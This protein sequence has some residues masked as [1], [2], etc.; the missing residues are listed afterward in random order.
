MEVRT[1]LIPYLYLTQAVR[2]GNIQQFQHIAN[3]TI[4]KLVFKTD[5]N[6]SLVQRLGHNVLKTGLK[7]ISLS[8][9]R[10]SFKDVA[11]KLH[12]SSPEATEFIC[13]KAIR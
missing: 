3:H 12:L 2:T 9:S 11:E 4:Y 8:Y 1:A 5:K 13:A 6:M 10:I 7:K